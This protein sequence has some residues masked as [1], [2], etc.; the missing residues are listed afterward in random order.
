MRQPYR[1]ELPLA[2][3]LGR[4]LQQ[5]RVKVNLATGNESFEAWRE[6]DHDDLVLATALACWYASRALTGPWGLNVI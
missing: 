2:E 1:S 6:R 3:V 4:E 5:F